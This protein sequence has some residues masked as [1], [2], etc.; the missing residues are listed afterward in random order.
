VAKPAKATFADATGSGLMAVPDMFARYT[1]VWRVKEA[2]ERELSKGAS[3]EA[4]LGGA[5]AAAEQLAL[6]MGKP[7]EW[8]RKWWKRWVEVHSVENA[9]GQGRRTDLA[10]WRAEL[11]GDIQA[12]QAVAQRG[13][14]STMREVYRRVEERRADRGESIPVSESCVRRTAAEHGLHVRRRPR[15]NALTPA[16]KAARLK[17]AKANKRRSLHDWGSW[18]FTDSKIF[19]SRGGDIVRG[20]VIST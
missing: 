9:A 6:E 4:A 13:R 19:V 18:L 7:V 1:L 8:G 20:K 12:V 16:H 2:V 3:R 17:F 14:A 15:G 11:L 10:G 5:A